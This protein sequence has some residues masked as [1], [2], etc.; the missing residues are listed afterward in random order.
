MKSFSLFFRVCVSSHLG[1]FSST[2]S[3]AAIAKL[4]KNMTFVQMMLVLVRDD[5]EVDDYVGLL[6]TPWK[7]DD[8]HDE[9]VE[10]L[11]TDYPVDHFPHTE[12]R[13]ISEFVCRK[14]G[15]NF[16]AKSEEMQKKYLCRTS[17]VCHMSLTQNAVKA[18]TWSK[19]TFEVHST[20]AKYENAS[21]RWWRKM[22]TNQPMEIKRRSKK[23]VEVE[24]HVS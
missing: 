13:N 11:L 16:K 10:G 3:S 5:I 7:T 20:A 21:F 9:C 2:G 17:S 18:M 12:K 15:L 19:K 23:C 1:L 24:L 8:D 6:M 22:A 4:W 14:N